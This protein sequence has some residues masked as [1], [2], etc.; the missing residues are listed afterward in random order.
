MA[1]NQLPSRP[2]TMC[3]FTAERR[4]ACN[5]ISLIVVTGLSICAT[6]PPTTTPCNL[7]THRSAN[8]RAPRSSR[9]TPS[10]YRD[11][12][13]QFH[14]AGVGRDRHTAPVDRE[15]EWTGDGPVMDGSKD[16]QDTRIGLTDAIPSN[17]RLG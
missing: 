12:P 7:R 17:R 11:Q 8:R 10:A 5:G 15:R 4:G 2:Y 6:L 9:H 14:P 1:T 3:A 13:A 16:R